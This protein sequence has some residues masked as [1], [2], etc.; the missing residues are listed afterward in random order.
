MWW[1]RRADSR[2]KGLVMRLL[3][4]LLFMSP[5]VAAAYSW[6]YDYVDYL[7]TPTPEPGCH[8]SYSGACL[9]PFAGDYD[10]IGGMGD[11]PYFTGKVY[12]VG[13]D[14]FALDADGDGLGCE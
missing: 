6:G 10:C 2:A 3:W 1:A 5:L 11:G 4:A 9:Y 13:P 7:G 14:E 8:Q 12:V